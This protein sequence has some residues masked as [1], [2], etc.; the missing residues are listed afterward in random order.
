MALEIRMTGP[1][2]DQKLAS[3]CAWPCED[4]D[5][6]SHASISLIRR[7]EPAEGAMG[8]AFDAIQLMIDSGFQ[9]LNFA[10]AYDAWR[11]SRRSR[12][13]VTI[14]H[15]GAEV[16]LDERR[17]TIDVIVRVLKE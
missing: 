5:V 9:A 2:S 16:T 8:S 7:A 15:D 13:K 14:E 1:D 11:S 12:P 6:H 3:L 4:V 17:N 10:L